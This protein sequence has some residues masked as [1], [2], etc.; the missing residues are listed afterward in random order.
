VAGAVHGDREVDSALV[1]VAGVLLAGG[2][3]AAM[4]DQQGLTALDYARR[5]GH[6]QLAAL[7]SGA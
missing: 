7:L 1:K 5:G 2:A 6:E 3:D 4:K